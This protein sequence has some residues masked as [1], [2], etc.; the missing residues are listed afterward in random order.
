MCKTVKIASFKIHKGFQTFAWLKGRPVQGAGTGKPF[1]KADTGADHRGNVL[2]VFG[3]DPLQ[4]DF[5]LG[6][7]QIIERS[8]L[9]NPIISQLRLTHPPKRQRPKEGDLHMVIS[10]GTRG[11]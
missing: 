6:G 9:Y 1:S 3:L 8:N 5:D 10:W 7:H 4:D 2:I 11:D